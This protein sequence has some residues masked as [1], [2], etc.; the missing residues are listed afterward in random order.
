MQR[1]LASRVGAMD[2]D[3][4]MEQRVDATIVVGICDHERSSTRLGVPIEQ[5][6]E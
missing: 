6:A 1:S 2:A 5:I 3:L 4:G